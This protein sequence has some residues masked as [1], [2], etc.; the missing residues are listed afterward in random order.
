MLIQTLVRQITQ[1]QLVRQQAEVVLKHLTEVTPDR[2]IQTAHVI[3]VTLTL[4]PSLPLLEEMTIHQAII[5]TAAAHRAEITHTTVLRQEA[6]QL[7]AAQVEAPVVA[8]TQTEVR[9]TAAQVEV[10][11][12]VA[13][14]EAHILQVA[15]HQEALQV[16]LP[17][18]VLH[19]EDHQAHRVHLVEVEDNFKKLKT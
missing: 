18:V 11:A 9:L 2:A 8:R 14:Q 19:Q 16:A 15:R 7:T 13:L 4:T 10:Q 3:M 6:V 17:Q 12:V 5:T 1:Q